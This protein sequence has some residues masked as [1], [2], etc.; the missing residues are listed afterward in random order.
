MTTAASNSP[1]GRVA[2][3]RLL[4]VGPLAIIAS[5]IANA[6]LQQI[7]AALLR[8]DPAFLP[9]SFG[10]PIFF[11]VVGVLGAVIV[12]ALVA[13]FARDPIPLFRRIA[14]VVL[15]VSFV[16]DV[17][18]LFANTPGATVANVV[19]LM[20][21]HVVAWAITVELLTRLTRA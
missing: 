17:L 19:V 5:A 6:L 14:L 1:T 3:G 12:F 20:L 4:W 18:M 7:A 8:P 2:L 21:M 15:I 11:T 9:L 16:P 13:R 10:P